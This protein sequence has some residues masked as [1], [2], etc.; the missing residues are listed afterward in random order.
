MGLKILID[1][2]G[3]VNRT[4]GVGQYSSQ[5]LNHLAEIDVYNNYTVLL[6]TELSKHPVLSL[7]KRDNFK[8]VRLSTPAIGIKRQ[9]NYLTISKKFDFDVYHCLNSNYPLVIKKGGVV[10]IHDLKYIKYPHYL[11]KFSFLKKRYLYYIFK[12]AVENTS[13]IIAVSKNTKNDIID[14]FG[15]NKQDKIKVIYEAANLKV[16]SGGKHI[17]KKYG[18]KQPYFLF[19]GEQRPHKNINGLL[20]A[21]NHYTKTTGNFNYSLV[22]SGKKHST[23]D[24]SLTGIDKRGSQNIIFTGFIDEEDMPYLYKYSYLFILPSFY[25]GFGIPILEAMQLGIPVITS[26]VSSMPEVAG[27]AC[28][29]VNPNDFKNVSAKIKMLTEDKALY[30]ELSNRG[31]KR[32]AEFSWDKVAKETLTLYQEVKQ[33]GLED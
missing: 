27:G 20:K 26:N 7:E 6:N 21:Y 1:A 13:K 24:N 30:K 2:L 5:L 9:V 28:L 8:I 16:K 31:Q 32:A 33:R 29:T 19:V 15:F 3:I 10:T 18:I 25:E 4:T 23:F 11:G 17:F 22:I 14:I 12:N